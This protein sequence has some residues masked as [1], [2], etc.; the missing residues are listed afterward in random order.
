MNA[1]TL[2]TTSAAIEE[3]SPDVSG[4]SGGYRHQVIVPAGYA[5]RDTSNAGHPHGL[6]QHRVLNRLRQLL[7]RG[8]PFDTSRR[9]PSAG[10]GGSTARPRARR[11]ILLRTRPTTPPATTTATTK[12][13]TP[14][15][16]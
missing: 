10:L 3:P 7:E 12:A 15:T 9:L 2:K 6:A 8:K 16:I 13:N 14:T 1:M 5:D 4:S 11:F